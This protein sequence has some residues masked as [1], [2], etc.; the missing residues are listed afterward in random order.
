MDEFVASG[1][2][3]LGGAWPVVWTLAKIVAVLL[4]ILGCVAYLT[5]WERKMIG[6]MHIRI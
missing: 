4:P 6:W 5:Y 1:S 3:L 2:Q